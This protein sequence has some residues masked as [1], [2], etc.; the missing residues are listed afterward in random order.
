VVGRVLVLYVGG[1]S[2]SKANGIT[3]IAPWINTARR[4][5]KATCLICNHDIMRRIPQIVSR[6]DQPTS[7]LAPRIFVISATLVAMTLTN[8]SLSGS[9]V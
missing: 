7:T 9:A 5:Y 6:R 4:F 1:T 3:S 2:R 8:P